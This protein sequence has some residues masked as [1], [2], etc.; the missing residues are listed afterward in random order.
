MSITGFALVGM[1]ASFGAATGASLTSIVFVF[2]LT[3]D[4]RIVLPLIVATVLADVVA[5][6]LLDDTLM[7]EKLTRRGVRVVRDYQADPF[8]R[9]SV[10]DVM[11]APALTVRANTPIAEVMRYVAAGAHSAYPVVDDLGRCRGIISRT[12]LL[13]R[14]EAEPGPAVDVASQDVV[15][16]APEASVAQAMELLIDESVEH[17]PVV[18]GDGVVI[19]MCTRTDIL[20]ARALQRTEEER[21]GAG[22]LSSLIPSG[23][24]RD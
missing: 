16:V 20:R 15:T 8:V 17:L 12:D 13:A 5:D 23:R 3:Q 4:Y 6:A 22:L 10:G 24:R 2:E 11:T 9:Q 7:T 19:G 14:S 18:N 21:Q 1:A